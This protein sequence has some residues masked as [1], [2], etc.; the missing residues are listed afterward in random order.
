MK[1]GILTYHSAY[2]F[3]ANLQVYS[4][5]EYLKN[6]G[7][8]PI[9]INWIPEDMAARS[10]IFV[11]GI[12]INAHDEFR[13]RFLPCTDICRTDADIIK[14]IKNENIKG[15]II[16]SD[17]VLQHQ[18]FL[19]RIYLSKKGIT[20]KNKTGSDGI[21]PNPFWG[22]FIPYFE[23]IFPVLVMSVSSQNTDFKYIRGRL[24]KQ[25]NIS[26]HRFSSI[27]VRDL[28]TKRMVKYL[29]YGTIDPPITPDPV[30]AYN[31]NVK[32]Q[33]S[34][35]EILNRFNLSDNYLLLSFRSRII[36]IE[37]MKSFQTIAEKNNFNCVA[38]T[39]PGGIPWE[40]PFRKIEPPLSPNEWYSLIKHSAGFIGEQMHPIIIALHNS[41]PFYSFDYYGIVSFKYFVN[42]KCSKIYNL[43]SSAG[44]LKNRVNMLGKGSRCPSPEEVFLQI[45]NFDSAKCNLFSINQLDKYNSMMKTISK[46]LI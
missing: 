44:F 22:S 34:K 40:T 7:F 6:N 32:D 14:V 17:A 15:I 23:E 25:M 30:F 10:S 18:P 31:Q 37:W 45:N 8:D 41:V 21:F 5:V 9:I 19:S 20:L 29:T 24:R 16:G 12:Q 46:F 42:E 35:E 11:S 13:K 1:I 39:T 3:G 26:L 2:N 28:W 43:L 4:T 36:S 38:L 27:T 33:Y